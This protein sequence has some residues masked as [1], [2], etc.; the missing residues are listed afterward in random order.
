EA[1][2]GENVEVEATWFISPDWPGPIVIGWKG[3]LERLRFAVDPSED[4]F[5]FGVW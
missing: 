3:C 4:T 2:E 1:E 5:Y